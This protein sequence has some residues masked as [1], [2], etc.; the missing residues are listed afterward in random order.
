M[1]GSEGVVARDISRAPIIIDN[2]TPY[3]PRMWS[4]RELAVVPVLS[5]FKAAVDEGSYAVGTNATFGTGVAG[6]NAAAFSATSAILSLLNKNGPSGA[7]TYIDYIRLIL[8]AVPTAGTR[9]DL[10]V[11]LDTIARAS[12][13][14]PVTMIGA[15]IDAASQGPNTSVLYNPTVAAAGPNVRQAGRSVIKAATPVVGDEYLLLFGSVEKA[16]PII[17]STTV[18]GRYIVPMAPLALGGGGFQTAL[19]HLWST[20]STAAPSFEFEVGLVE[21]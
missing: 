11:T 1:I 14:T 15:N 9:F 8:T 2:S 10:G 20:S 16:G 13:G 18:A 7:R 21:R 6:P 3:P 17:A 12:A 5:D 4:R 19:I